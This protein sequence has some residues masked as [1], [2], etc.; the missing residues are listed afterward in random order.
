MS[1][2]E[3]P[4]IKTDGS[5]PL[6]RLISVMA[7]KGCDRI[8]IK[9]LADNDNSKNQVYLGSGFESIN[10][11]P[12][13]AITPDKNGLFKAY[14]DFSW[15]DMDGNEYLAPETKFI[16]Y[17]QYPEIRFSGFLK[18]CKNA[19]SKLMAARMAGR[20][21]FFGIRFDGK[22]YGY[23]VSPA[24][25]LASETATYTNLPQL[26]VFNEIHIVNRTVGADPKSLLLAKLER[27]HR[28]GWI[29][30]KR[31]NKHKE[32]LPCLSSNC[33]GY[34]LETEL[35]I[36]PNG[37]SEPDFHG[38]EVKQHSVKKFEKYET[39]VLTLMTPEPTGG[40]YRDNGV[41][42]FIR[43]Y[44]YPDKNGRKDRLNFGGVH[45]A[46]KPQNT[47]GLTLTLTGY[48]YSKEKIVS[49]N[50]S[51][52][53]IRNGN[54]IAAAWYFSDLLAHW[55]R[56]HNQAVYIPSLKRNEPTLQYHYSNLIRICEGTDFLKLLKAFANGKVY[57]DPGIKLENASD[58]MKKKTK[59]RSQFRVKSKDIASLYKKV[60]SFNVTSKE[61]IDGSD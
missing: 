16:L 2:I 31:F 53:L 18:G 27:I 60:T 4:L 32:I 6:S 5:S 7:D 38:W 28:A 57:Y 41:E 44:G 21:L 58:A 54:E 9:S 46:N 43:K 36:I 35:G 25:H 55:N 13:L 33:G 11:F 61:V 26:G 24:D 10:Y 47:T 37:F 15:V 8:L 19:P 23:V 20:I 14:P 51:V 1:E 56:K 3:A 40:Y 52:A 29:N 59:R 39:G 42:D 30:S 49:E 12:N 45:V 48:D 17:P 34:T 22:I 50:G